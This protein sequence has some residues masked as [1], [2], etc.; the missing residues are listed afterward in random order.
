MSAKIG[1]TQKLN[2][3]PTDRAHEQIRHRPF[4]SLSESFKRTFGVKQIEPPAL[5]TVTSLITNETE[6][7]NFV[8]AAHRF[9]HGLTGDQVHKC[10]RHIIQVIGDFMNTGTNTLSID[11]DIG[12]MT[13]A[14]SVVS[15]RF[16]RN[17]REMLGNTGLL[18]A[19]SSV[20][21]AC[22]VYSE[23]E[24]MDS[25]S[26]I[27][28]SK[29]SNISSSV[30]RDISCRSLKSIVCGA[31]SKY[32]TVYK[33]AVSRYV[34]DIERRARQ[35][36]LDRKQFDEQINERKL[37]EE[38]KASEF[39]RK[40]S[41]YREYLSNQI[42]ENHCK[43]KNE[44]KKFIEA[45]SCHNF[46]EL[47]QLDSGDTPFSKKQSEK[48]IQTFLDGQVKK[49]AELRK[50]SRKNEMDLVNH[51][52]KMNLEKIKKG[53]ESERKVKSRQQKE[54]LDSWNQYAALNRR[55]REIESFDVKR[56]SQVY[57]R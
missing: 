45:A 25:A 34:C 35:A 5:A 44:K 32:E 19:S 12:T 43:R 9:S 49:S 36:M 15:F 38:L 27:T 40:R 16:N 55:I 8:K 13:C 28:S 56:P 4:F 37:E 1:F 10:F 6:E 33:A 24:P 20:S 11:F 7:L 17:I 41:E 31:G 47:N 30:S 14:S 21:K 23:I 57:M 48:D 50:A 29:R 51:V 3:G 54:L 22:T 18:D 42:K 26:C 53:E 52:N 39:K 46:P 2:E